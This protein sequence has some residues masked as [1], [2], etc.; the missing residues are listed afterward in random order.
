MF[1]KYSSLVLMGV[2]IISLIYMLRSDDSDEKVANYRMNNVIVLFIHFINFAVIIINE[3]SRQYVIFYVLQ[4][5]AFL[6]YLLAFRL[7]YKN[8]NL[9]VLNTMFM[10]LAIG[11]IILTRLNYPKAHKQFYIMCASAAISLVIPLF[12]KKISAAKALAGVLGVLG[13]GALALVLLISRTTYGANLSLSLGP[14]S[15]QPSEFVKVTYVLLLAMLFRERRDWRRICFA[16]FIA[17][18]HTGILVLSKDLGGALIYYL[19][20]ICILYVATH[21]ARYPLFGLGILSLGAVAA[22]F[23]FSHVRVRVVAWLNPWSVVDS[24]GYQIAQSLFSIS[25]GSWFGKGLFM[26]EPQYIPV[27]EKDFIFSAIAEEF[28]ALFSIMLIGVCLI[29]IIEMIK[30]AG[31]CKV[32][33]FKLLCV[34][35]AATYA[36]Q[37]FLTV[38]GDLKFIPST[39]VTLALVSYGGS[40]LLSTFIL[41]GVIQGVHCKL[42]KIVEA[43]NLESKLKKESVE[44]RVKE[45][46]RVVIKQKVRR[47][48]RKQKL[49]LEG[50]DVKN[51]AQTKR[52][53]ETYRLAV[54][55]GAIFASCALYMVYFVIV[56]ANDTNITENSYNLARVNAHSAK[57]VRGNIVSSDGAVLAT[58]VTDEAGNERRTYNYNNLFSHVVGYTGSATSG[59]ESLMNAKLLTS[60]KSIQEQIASDLNAEKYVGDTVNITIDSSMQY[61]AYMALGDQKG[62]VVVMDAETGDILVMVSKPDYNPNDIEAI[63]A[64]I[65]S[66]TNGESFLVNRAT[67]GLY[68][69]GSTF[70]IITTLAYMRAVGETFNDYT[71]DCTGSLTCGTTKVNCSD[72]NVHG[73]LTIT[74]GLE[75]SC[76]GTFANMAIGMENSDLIDTCQSLLFNS[77]LPYSLG[78]KK[79][80]FAITQESS[81]EER[82]LVGFGQGKTLV[83]P[84]HMCMIA[85]AI[86]ND[87]VLMTPRIVDSVVSATG[88]LVEKYDVTEYGTL[89]SKEEA[90]WLQEAMLSV[91]ANGTANTIATDDYYSG[92]KTGSAQFGSSLENLHALYF[93]FAYKEGYHKLAV[94]VVV[95]EGGS[96]GRVAAPIAKAVFDY[97][98]G[99]TE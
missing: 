52:N 81:A 34:G 74:Q 21:K 92:G 88:T 28:G 97:Y 32:I 75:R 33:F 68:P 85:S 89:M 9:I 17:L 61:N 35:L 45:N 76:N 39:G 53:K 44:R 99:V 70:K 27:V 37:T 19:S 65:E 23:M 63:W 29:L 50:N 15:V 58:T 1:A 87:G 38:G 59:I 12:L 95:E 80:S 14:I 60:T 8:C 54:I 4:L 84:L 82:M 66:Y 24:S 22:Y 91:V 98:F 36:V 55:F 42:V 96:G 18:A 77:E 11:M 67:N 69:P 49:I 93:G 46:G 83:T 71:Y 3:P 31:N 16:T 78:Y 86:A 26:G 7:I 51:E 2:F 64:N 62:A 72:N 94:A 47:P 13:I 30:I 79:S 6:V 20:F 90:A 56:S 40:S 48:N 25:G 41:I 10:L 73:L 5:V 43:E 57:I